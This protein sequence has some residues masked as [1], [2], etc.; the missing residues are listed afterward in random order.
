MKADGNK[1]MKK[2]WVTLDKN[3][4]YIYKTSQEKNPTERISLYCAT[5]KGDAR[6]K[7][8]FDLLTVT[9]TYN[10]SAESEAEAAQWINAMMEACQSLILKQII[11][12]KSPDPVPSPP[13]DKAA[14]K[15]QEQQS[16]EL[17]LQIRDL[18]ENKACSECNAP[19]PDWAAIN[20][21]VFF[22]IDCS[23]IHRSLGVHI[24][25]VRSVL[26]DFWDPS[27]ILTMES[28]GNKRANDYWEH[29]VPPNHHKPNPKSSSEERETW[30]RNKYEQRQFCDPKSQPPG[31]A[32]PPTQPVQT[33][34]PSTTTTQSNSPQLQAHST[35]P[36]PAQHIPP[37][38]D[39]PTQEEQAPVKVPGLDFVGYGFFSFNDDPAR[40]ILRRQ[41][42]LFKN[43]FDENKTAHVAINNGPHGLRRRGVGLIVPDHFS[44]D[45][46]VLGYVPA[47]TK[48]FDTKDEFAKF[49]ASHTQPQLDSYRQTVPMHRDVI[50]NTHTNSDNKWWAVTEVF[51]QLYELFVNQ[52]DEDGL[53]P[54][55]VNAAPLL[56]KGD[57]NMLGQ[58]IKKNGTHFVRSAVYGGRL[59]MKTE[60]D[61]AA[62]PGKEQVAQLCT[63]NFK[64]VFALDAGMLDPPGSEDLRAV[65]NYT[66]DVTGGDNRKRGLDW[67]D[68]VWDKPQVLAY[69]LE[70]ISAVFDDLSLSVKVEAAI[71]EHID[72]VKG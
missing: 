63:T 66:L 38:S 3:F 7:H 2:V 19:D 11:G 12:V 57:A 1:K 30:I 60:V 49:L 8:T 5:P 55:V 50:N 58:F 4:L 70:S 26:L 15:A 46:S 54:H 10:F 37:R 41:R 65:Q 47:T 62:V 28:I 21:G 31:S 20:L 23:G 44:V 25:Q 64:H 33:P 17:V 18:P 43:S 24:S 59:L 68:S 22:C 29:H 32:P 6:K 13:I 45:T 61:K 40:P 48:V 71:N 56:A 69:E 9:N 72:R 52:V 34:P 39:T 42:G 53:S 16:R 67:I 36:I 27:Q 35:P 14:Q 51:V